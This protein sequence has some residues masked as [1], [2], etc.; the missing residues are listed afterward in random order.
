M[1]RLPGED[2]CQHLHFQVSDR[3]KA[4][5]FFLGKRLQL[6]IASLELSASAFTVFSWLDELKKAE[7]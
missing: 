6:L 4:K 1:S 5:L 3:Y 2:V 7:G